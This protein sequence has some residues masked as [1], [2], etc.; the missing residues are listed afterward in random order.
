MSVVRGQLYHGFAQGPAEVPQSTPIDFWKGDFGN[1][2]IHRNAATPERIA[3]KT[4]LWCDILAKMP[5]FPKSVLEIGANVGINIHALRGL[6]PEA[7]FYA[8]EPNDRARSVLEEQK[9][10]TAAWPSTRECGVVADLALTAGVMIHVPPD[11]LYGFCEEIHIRAKRWIVAIEYFSHEPRE[12]TYRGHAGK[13]WTRDF[14]SFWL[15]N[16]PDL[17][18]VANG[19]AWQRTSGLDDVHWFLFSK[20]N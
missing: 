19:F 2:Y 16:F 3:Q 14:G 7:T 9:L 1:D 12:V 17:T 4:A 13:L 5:E 8:V 18:P 20:E 10:V 15:D 11:R 6:C